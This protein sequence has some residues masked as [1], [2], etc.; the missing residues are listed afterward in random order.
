MM[1]INSFSRLDCRES[2]WK[3]SVVGGPG[4]VPG[5]S[6]FRQMIQ[7]LEDLIGPHIWDVSKPNKQS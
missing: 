1:N 7:V 6:S 5:T 4:D 3:Q 2:H